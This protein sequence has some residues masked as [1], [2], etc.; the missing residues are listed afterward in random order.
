MNLHAIVNQREQWIKS[1]VDNEVITTPALVIDTKEIQK[2]ISLFTEYLPE[3][4]LFYAVKANNT[5]QL[6]QYLAENGINFDVASANE[7]NDLRALG[8]PPSRMILSNPIKSPYTINTFFDQGMK[9][10]VVD[11]PLDLDALQ[12]AKAIRSRKEDAGVFVRIRISST[13]VQIDLNSKF[14]CN[15]TEAVELLKLASQAGFHARGVQFH[16]GTQSWNVTNYKIGIE[17]ALRIFNQAWKKHKIK[18]DSI[19]IGGG[20]PDP[21]VVKEAGGMDRFFKE[22]RN[23]ISPAIEAGL[24]IIAEPGRIMVSGACSAVCSIVGKSIRNGTPWI[25]LD[26]GAYGLFSGKFFDHKEFQF[27]VLKQQNEK[28]VST[29]RFIPYVVAGPTCDSIDLISQKAHLPE[30][31]MPGD[32]LCAHN[33]G[34]YSIV[35]ACGF[36]GFGEI[37]TYLGTANEEKQYA[38]SPNTINGAIESSKIVKILSNAE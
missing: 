28:I 17:T 18:C 38:Q 14:G 10:L 9:L 27:H 34:A 19:N 5:P 12:K 15:E 26:D 20:Y 25:Y 30:N 8:I 29:D 23:A 33:M 35:T 21:W 24:N 31:L 6:I 1:L 7:I 4:K 36:N 11:N 16:V 2:V 32:V 13:D 3:A 37:G 22:L